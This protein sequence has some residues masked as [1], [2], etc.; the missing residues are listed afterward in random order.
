[1]AALLKERNNDLTQAAV[2][3]APEV[4]DVL[5]TLEVSGGCLLARMSGSGATCFGLFGGEADAHQAAAAISKATPRWWVVATR[6]T[7]DSAKVTID[8]EIPAAF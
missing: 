4:G 5:G 2:F 7:A 8:T 1:L 6:L 3:L